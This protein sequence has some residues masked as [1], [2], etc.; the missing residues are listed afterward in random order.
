MCNRDAAPSHLRVKV[1][2]GISTC[3]PKT[4]RVKGPLEHVQTCTHKLSNSIYVVNHESFT[5]KTCKLLNKAYCYKAE[6]RLEI[7]SEIRVMTTSFIE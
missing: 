4:V 6:L 1:I 3:S 5:R 7:R 2:T